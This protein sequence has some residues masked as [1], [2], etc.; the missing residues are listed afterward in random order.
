MA[1]IET[2]EKHYSSQKQD[3]LELLR[4]KAWESFMQRGL[5]QKNEEA[6]QYLTL[7]N[8]TADSFTPY[9]ES[10]LPKK[11]KIAKQLLPECKGNAL[12]FVN[13]R[14]CKELSRIPKEVVVLPLHE[15]LSTYGHFLKER[16]N[17]N[18]SE[19]KDPFALLAFSFL[20][21]IFLYVPPKCKLKAALQCHHIVSGEKPFVAQTLSLFVGRD[22]EVE[23]I[24]TFQREEESPFWQ[25]SLLDVALDEGARL[26]HTDVQEKAASSWQ[27]TRMR[28]TLKRSSCLKTLAFT[29]GGALHRNDYQISLL[30]EGAEAHLQGLA[31]IEGMHTAHT[32]VLM[33]HHAP[34]TTSRQLFKN[35][36]KDSSQSSFIGKIW[37]KRDAQKTEA[38]QLNNN[39]LLGE[40][41]QA[42]SKPN[43]EIF[44]DDVK[45]SHGATVAQ[46]DDALLFYLKTRGIS[47]EDAK[48]LLTRA[49]CREILDQLPVSLRHV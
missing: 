4:K 11:E 14:F 27:F 15:A 36:M 37:V 17:K 24:S 25:N 23:L 46:L 6:F 1:L 38:Y 22:A 2:L 20:Q 31:L 33:E 44:A 40:H 21:G 7:R 28:A 39:L 19:E 8:L 43:L 9:D 41:A 16:L 29:R 48:A 5:P 26:T 18:L 3:A 30:G 42:N 32:H 47:Q 35:V 12:V 49:F 45:A 13:G 10:L 34:H